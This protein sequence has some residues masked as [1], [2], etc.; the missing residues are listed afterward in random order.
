M[1]DD[2]PLSPRAIRWFAGVFYALLAAAGLIWIRLRTGSWLPESLLGGQTFRS[3][4][5]GTGLA[6]LTISMTGKLIRWFPWMRWLSLEVRRLLGPLDLFTV[7]VLALAS[8]IGEEIFFRGA[9]LPVGGLVFSSLVFGLIHTGPD[10]R[11]L[12]WSAFAIVIGFALGWIALET[13]SLAGPI[14]AHVVIN[15]VNLGR[16]SRLEIPQTPVDDP[17]SR[18]SVSP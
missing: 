16:I 7:I 9:F 5:L 8:G 2:Q 6:F 1:S 13:G 3:L 18:D 11:F 10:R 17:T 15:A 12:A 4:Y 14:L